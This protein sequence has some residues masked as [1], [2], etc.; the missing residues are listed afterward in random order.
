MAPDALPSPDGPISDTARIELDDLRRRAAESD[1]Q[2][3]DTNKILLSLYRDQKIKARQLELERDQN[4]HQA[5]RYASDL[6]QAH[7]QVRDNERELADTNSQLRHYAIDLRK[8]IANLK[9]AN[10]ELEDAY[11]DTIR[12]LVIAAEYKD[13][14]TGNHIT[15]ISRYCALLAEKI[16]MPPDEVNAILYAS[17]M[18][19]IGKIGIPD[20]I[21]LSVS[22]ANITSPN[23]NF[24]S[25]R[26]G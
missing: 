16:G 14:D 21:L 13:R 2:K 17:P 20:H 18:H 10:K 19:D 9:Q 5:R 26:K 23:I 25:S 6:N 7:K 4:A 22:G 15:R 12:R 11:F 8:T 3:G 1:L 24:G